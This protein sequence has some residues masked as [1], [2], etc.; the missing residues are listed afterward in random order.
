MKLYS[1]WVEGR[2]GSVAFREAIALADGSSESP[3]ESVLRVQLWQSKDPAIKKVEPQARI[4]PYRVD[5]LVNGRVVVE[6][7]GKHKYGVDGQDAGQQIVAEKQR[8]N[9]LERQ[10]YRVVRVTWDELFE[11]VDGVS[12]AVA[13]VLLE[14]KTLRW[15]HGN[16]TCI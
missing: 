9:Y 2:K 12:A 10:G 11:Q 16:T 4:G 3:G 7:D 13:R 15:A 8:H 14:V 6:F 1:Q 5:L